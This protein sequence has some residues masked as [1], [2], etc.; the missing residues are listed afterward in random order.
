MGGRMFTHGRPARQPAWVKI[1]P[2]RGIP[3][4]TTWEQGTVVRILGK[5]RPNPH[6]Y[7]AFLP[8][9]LSTFAPCTLIPYVT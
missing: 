5:A 9:L 6:P 4:G 8:Q 7:G 3:W 1:T 2:I